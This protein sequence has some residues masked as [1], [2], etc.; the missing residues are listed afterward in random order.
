MT[1]K[2][3][4]LKQYEFLYR[5]VGA[6]LDGISEEESIRQPAPGGNCTNWILGHLIVVQNNALALLGE[7]PILEHENLPRGDQAPVTGPENAIPF[8]EARERFLASEKRF[9]AALSRTTE[10]ELREGG[11]SD[12]FGDTT[13]KGGLLNLIAFHQAYHAGQL[14][15]SRRLVGRAGVIKPPATSAST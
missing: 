5:T 12:P 11:F 2:E 8:G 3:A 6:N 7:P 15:L 14:G 9:L 1:I 4:L 13:T 10:A